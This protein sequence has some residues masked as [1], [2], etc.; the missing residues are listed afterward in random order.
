MTTREYNECVKLYSDG[1]FRFI[2]KNLRDE[3]ESENI[4]QNTFEKLWIRIDQVEMKTA[5]SYLFKVAYNNMIDVIRKNKRNVDLEEAGHI[6][7]TNHEY[8]NLIEYVNK[9]LN[10]LPEKQ[11]AAITLRDYEGHDYKAIGD[12]TGMSESQVK[13]NIFRARK[14]IKEY[15][16]K[17]ETLTL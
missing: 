4:V 1:I 12:I 7:S 6:A 9:A 2:V 17:L 5:K 14:F 11:K 16:G 13:V 10:M 15:I 8:N 3:F